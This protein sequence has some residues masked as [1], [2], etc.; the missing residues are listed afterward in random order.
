MISS[1]SINTQLKLR[2]PV[3]LFGPLGLLLLFAI[4]VVLATWIGD[5]FVH[6]NPR[7]VLDLAL[8]GIIATALAGLR[9]GTRL[10]G[11]AMVSWVLILRAAFPF[12][13]VG[14]AW[15]LG[16]GVAALVDGDAA[17]LAASLLPAIEGLFIGAIVGAIAGTAVSW[18]CFAKAD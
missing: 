2:A 8:P 15:P 18:L 14:F 4:A 9:I 11:R 12:A 7:G 3:L 5:G 6:F 10:R 17:S 16:F 13:A 1:P